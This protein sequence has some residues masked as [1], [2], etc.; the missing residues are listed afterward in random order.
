M[1]MGTGKSK[2][3][4][5]TCAHKYLQGQINGLLIVAPNGVHQNW[6]FEEIPKHLAVA[7]T[8]TAYFSARAK[9]QKQQKAVE[10]VLAAPGLAVLTM[11]YDSLLTAAGRALAEKFL[12]RRQTMMVLDESARIKT[13]KAKRTMAITALG[14]RAAYRWILTGTPV[15]NGPFDVYSQIRFLKEDFWKEFGLHP[16][17]VFKR[18]FGVFEPRRMGTK[19]FE[20]CVGYQNLD[21][22]HKLISKVSTRVTKDECLDLPPKLYQKMYFELNA[23]QQRLYNALRDDYMVE[24][25]GGAGEITAPLAIVR[26]TRLQQITSGF[27]TIDGEE[28]PQDISE[29]DN[30]R[31]DLLKQVC[32]DLDSA[33]IWARYKR[34][35]DLIK[36]ALKD[37]CVVIDGRV[38][39]AQRGELIAKFQSGQVRFFVANPAAISEGVTLHRT[40]TVV[41]YSNSFK[42]SE[43][44][45]SEDRAHR[46]GQKNNVTIIDIAAKGTVDERIIE[47]LRNK[48]N[49]AAEVTGDN[50]KEWI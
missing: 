32:E 37:E 10:E 48:S 43:R 38:P 12:E 6:V 1:D 26:L 46:I 16:F 44:L 5:D 49:I 3:C 22:L 33:I 39:D 17:S 36:H 34:D 19:R 50:L 15:A 42:L 28:N 21:R 8:S 9:T 25:Q 11:S 41:Y 24:L 27:I 23:E 20:Q 14:R 18:V 47:A 45:Q 30:P 2:V 7:C 40:S 13:P 29:H 35:I 31:L 4:L